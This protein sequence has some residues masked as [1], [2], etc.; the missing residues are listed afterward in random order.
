M[1]TALLTSGPISTTTSVL[2]YHLRWTIIHSS[3]FSLLF[4]DGVKM[5]LV[6]QSSM[7]GDLL[8]ATVVPG[9]EA[10]T[11]VTAGVG[12]IDEYYIY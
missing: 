7:P 8:P 6:D 9:L 10:L 11:T 4:Q 12:V 5:T 3:I 2:S 1:G